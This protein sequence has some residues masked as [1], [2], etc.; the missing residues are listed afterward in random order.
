MKATIVPAR[1]FTSA[2]HSGATD[3]GITLPVPGVAIP[4]T[5]YQDGPA[6][7]LDKLDLH[8]PQLGLQGK[9]TQIRILLGLL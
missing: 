8:A 5:D 7:G 2:R 9:K 4:D 1:S 3:V 6:Q